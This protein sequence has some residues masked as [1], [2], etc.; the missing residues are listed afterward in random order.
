MRQQLDLFQTDFHSITVKRRYANKH[1]R[2]QVENHATEQAMRN[3][4][5]LCAK[6]EP[7]VAYYILCERKEDGR[8][9]EI[10][11]IQNETVA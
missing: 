7:N 1:E 5:E 2:S 8:V 6:T 10:E 4:V 11:R 3:Y 9:I